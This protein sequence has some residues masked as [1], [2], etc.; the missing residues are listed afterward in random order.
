[1]TTLP[2]APRGAKH[3]LGTVA[4]ALTRVRH[5]RI[6]VPV[7]QL[8]SRLPVRKVCM[9]RFPF[10][11]ATILGVTLAM[12]LG[13]AL[14][15]SHAARARQSAAPVSQQAS[16]WQARISGHD[17][18]PSRLIAVDKKQQT[19]F[20]FER[21]SP[22]RLAQQYMCTTGQSNGDK[23]TEGDL[24]T[25]EG[26]YFVVHRLAS[27]LNFEK[28]GYEA[29][30]LN[31]P[32]P[33][34]RLRNKTGYGIWIH[35]RGVPITP[36]VTEGCVSL[37][38]EDIAVLGKNLLPGTPVTLAEA[39]NFFPQT[40]AEDKTVIDTLHRKTFE[41]AKAWSGRSSKFF[42]Y[43]DP[44]AYAIAQGE[45][46]TAF[47]AQKES[48]FKKV[49]YI[50]TKV[51]NVQALQG[52]GYWVT[53]FQQDYRASNL[54]S[55][56]VRR[57]YWQKDGKGEFRIVGMEWA[58]HLNGTLTAGLNEAP[59]AATVA[60]AERRPQTP[61]VKVAPMPKQAPPEQ[62]RPEPALPE[63]PQPAPQPVGVATLPPV[64]IGKT[65]A[66]EPAPKPAVSVSAA[67]QTPPDVMEFIEA[68]RTAWE[69]GDLNAYAACY[70]KTAI[71]GGRKGASAI[72]SHKRVL[73]GK[74]SPKQVEL[75]NIRITSKQGI[76]T[77]DMQQAYTD[78]KSFADMGIKTL[79]LRLKNNAW[80]IVREDWSPMQQ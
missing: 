58:P 44:K 64:P 48:V 28:Y 26:V 24:K 63:A 41:W 8:N 55:K 52:P 56:G 14:V 1:M 30:T 20:L 79:H 53:W 15:P 45:S 3:L 29:Y 37:N 51:R 34:D 69:K 21:H 25:P 62:T 77:A 43:Y 54:S 73:W 66:S 31:Y 61:P 33:V 12:A 75:T 39:V 42:D 32:N 23:F 57:L 38:N 22:L 76:L 36:N 13:G 10:R 19:L 4:S 16:G 17:A 18:S 35:G 9:I 74:S 40:P 7:R 70:D 2:R 60:V 11:C 80:R 6:R 71:Q 46:F 72:K 78:S 49:A 65:T 5:A 59:V 27:G 67:K 47:R 68:W 50:D